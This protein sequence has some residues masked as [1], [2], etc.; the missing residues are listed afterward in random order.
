MPAAT[1]IPE[2]KWP[3]GILELP[4]SLEELEDFIQWK[5]EI[6]KEQKWTG[7]G[8][9]TI[10]LKDFDNTSTIFKRVMP[11]TI[12]GLR[13]CIRDNGAYDD[14]LEQ[15]FEALVLKPKPQP[16]TLIQPQI[17]PQI[18]AQLST[19]PAARVRPS[20]LLWPQLPGL[21]SPGLESTGSSSLEA[22]A[23]DPAEV[24]DI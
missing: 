22:P 16:K 3:T 10:Y 11:K 2:Q 8:L 17:E 5:V 15:T 12:F 7:S 13:Q 21:S 24:S 18:Q 14:E 4:A 23:R 1:L 20:Q 6:Y 9:S 19:Q